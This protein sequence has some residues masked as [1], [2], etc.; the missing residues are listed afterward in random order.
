M[1]PVPGQA[2][3]RKCLVA[4]CALFKS[5]PVIP[6]AGIHDFGAHFN[7]SKGC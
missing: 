1:V 4:V 3:S 7:L 5:W 2:Q 6:V